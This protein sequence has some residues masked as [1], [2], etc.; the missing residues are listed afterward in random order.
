MTLRHFSTSAAAAL[1]FAAV[2]MAQSPCAL[3]VAPP[4][5]LAVKRDQPAEQKLRVQLPPGCHTNSDKPN[6]AYLIP[7]KLTWN[8]G[9]L[10]VVAVTFPK[11]ALEKYAFSEQPLSVFSGDFEITTS[12]RRSATAAPGPASLSGKLRY[13]ACNDKMCFPPKTVE[14]K[15]PLLL[16]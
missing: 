13:Q 5:K 3:T 2:A 6:E 16:Q 10:E 15:L 11:P 12:F 1:L 7:L 9:P 4:A 14:V 8:P